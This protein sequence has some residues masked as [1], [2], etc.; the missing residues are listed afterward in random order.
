MQNLLIVEDNIAQS[1]HLAN[2]LCRDVSN[3]RLYGIVSTCSEAMEIVKNNAVDIIILDLKLPD[4]SGDNLVKFIEKNNLSKY[5][6]SIIILTGETD[7]LQKVRRNKYIYYYCT[8][9]G[10]YSSI[11]AHTKELAD[12]KDK[13]L[14]CDFINDEIKRNMEDLKFDF[15]YKGTIYLYECICEMFLKENRFDINLDNEIYPIIAKKYNKT[16][17]SIKVNIFHSISLMY[18]NIDESVL[19]SYLGYT[20]ESKPKTKE[21]ITSIIIHILNENL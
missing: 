9:L 13:V 12:I 2:S 3:I 15:S 8:K 20:I 16:K 19:S 11:I 5:E 6:E 7:M 4:L 18:Y 21:I 10:S 17:N 1:Y 14:T